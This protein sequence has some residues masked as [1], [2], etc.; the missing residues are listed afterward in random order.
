MTCCIGRNEWNSKGTWSWEYDVWSW[1]NP[2][3][4]GL[5]VMSH[6]QLTDR[7]YPAVNIACRILYLEK[8]IFFLQRVI[9]ASNLLTAA[10]HSWSL[11]SFQEYVK[12][13]KPHQT[14]RKT[15]FFLNRFHI[16]WNNK[17]CTLFV[18]FTLFYCVNF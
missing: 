5:V 6:L 10:L 1:T 3:T 7:I 12:K 18:L 9:Q 8:E 15:F 13:N 14:Q 11:Y 17:I 2:L 4:S 16:N